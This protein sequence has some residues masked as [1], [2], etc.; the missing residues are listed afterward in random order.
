MVVAKTYGLIGNKY[1][2]DRKEPLSNQKPKVATPSLNLCCLHER[3]RNGHL[4]ARRLLI[5]VVLDVRQ[6]HMPSVQHSPE[7]MD[8]PLMKL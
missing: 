2:T 8:M 3:V 5:V 4:V 6:C 1:F 7:D